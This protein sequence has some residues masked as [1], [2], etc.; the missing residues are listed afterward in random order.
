MRNNNREAAKLMI[1][2][3]RDLN[4]QDEE[5]NT[6]LSVAV[7]SGNYEVVEYLADKNCDINIAN[8]SLHS[9]LTVV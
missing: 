4:T 3:I 2:K 6:L 5:G 1:E 9:P 7:Q 8:V